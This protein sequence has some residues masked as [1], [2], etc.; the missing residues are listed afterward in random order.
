MTIS[1]IKWIETNISVAN[2]SEFING[3]GIWTH[4][5]TP[6]LFGPRYHQAITTTTIA[7]AAQ[8]VQLYLPISPFR[9]HSERIEAAQLLRK[10]PS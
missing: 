4:N 6:S 5:F 7:A 1:S 8:F 9:C 10:M 3:L 2:R